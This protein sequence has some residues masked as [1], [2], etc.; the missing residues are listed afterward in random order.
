M[1]SRQYHPRR[2]I[3]SAAGCE[4]VACAVDFYRRARIAQPADDEVASL[5]VEIGERES[6]HTSF[7]RGADLGQFHQ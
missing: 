5:T 4:D 1:A 7:G 6:T 2:V 3:P